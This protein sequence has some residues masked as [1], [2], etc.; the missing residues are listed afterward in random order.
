MLLSGKLKLNLRLGKCSGELS[1]AVA[2][3][4]PAVRWVHVRGPRLEA[5]ATHRLLID[6]FEVCRNAHQPAVL[7]VSSKYKA[8]YW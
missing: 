4:R 2:S 7:V 1:T 3:G 8:R 6:S 5:G